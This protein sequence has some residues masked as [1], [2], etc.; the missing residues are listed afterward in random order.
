M[1]ILHLLPREERFYDFFQRSSQ[2]IVNGAQHLLDLVNDFQNLPEKVER[3][4]A[5]ENY[6]DDITHEVIRL[7]H[8]TFVT[9]L[10]REDILSL[11]QRLDDVMDFIEEAA[12]EMV[13]YRIAAPTQKCRELA[14]NLLAVTKKVDEAIGLLAKHQLNSLLEYGIR[15]HSHENQADHLYREAMVELFSNPMDLADAMKWREIYLNLENATDRCEDVANVLE[16]IVLK[17]A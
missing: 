16:G 13:D 6:G 17:Y 3:I 14:E 11:A 10:D 8:R 15:I 4:I 9:P 12:R 5:C 7:A 2:N 1:P